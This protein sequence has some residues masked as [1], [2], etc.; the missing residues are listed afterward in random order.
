MNINITSSIADGNNLA[1]LP[2]GLLD[3]TENLRQLSDSQSESLLCISTYP[4]H[5]DLFNNYIVS[6]PDGLLANTPQL[7]SL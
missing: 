7:R 5:S 4:S 3:G 2:A 6:L 1:E